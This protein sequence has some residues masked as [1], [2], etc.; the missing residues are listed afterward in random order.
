MDYFI[1]QVRKID[2][3]YTEQIGELFYLENG[4]EYIE[5]GKLNRA[6]IEG[7]IAEFI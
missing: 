5:D 1:Y 6:K 2:C 7:E 3:A 4:E